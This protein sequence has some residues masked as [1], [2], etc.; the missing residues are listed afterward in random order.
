MFSLVDLKS[1]LNLKKK[2]HPEIQHYCPETPFIIVGTKLDLF[3]NEE[4]IE[5]NDLEKDTMKEEIGKLRS[6]YST[7]PY[8]EISSKT[9][10]NIDE[11]MISGIRYL[12]E[13]HKPIESKKECILS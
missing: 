4:Y 5:K 9:G 2:F 13:F 1:L 6:L 7:V 3:E 8:F 11:T 12:F 10:I